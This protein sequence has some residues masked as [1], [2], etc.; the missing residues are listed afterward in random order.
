MRDCG[1]GGGS[2]TRCVVVRCG[3]ALT[4]LLVGGAA[5]GCLGSGRASSPPTAARLAA[6]IN[7]CLRKHGA[8]M[9]S[10]V[11]P[12]A[13]HV[14]FKDGKATRYTVAIGNA[15]NTSTPFGTGGSDDPYSSGI[16]WKV[17]TG[18]DER[19]LTR[20]TAV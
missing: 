7:P 18:P 8:T 4:L 19:A 17:I 16:S 11:G 2:Y 1:V 6:Q 13:W 14:Q 9:I 10:R 12:G 15:H 3:I 20:C 5:S